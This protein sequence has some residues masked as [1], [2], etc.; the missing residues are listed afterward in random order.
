MNQN[1]I[2]TWLLLAFIA[3]GAGACAVYL[4]GH[5]STVI[6]AWLL[7]HGVELEEFRARRK[8]RTNRMIEEYGVPVPA[9][10]AK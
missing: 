3:T 6:G 2:N 10:Q 1:P 9:E 5:L 8:A 7:S 4:S